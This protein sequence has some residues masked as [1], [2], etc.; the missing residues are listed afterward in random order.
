[1]AQRV[2]AVPRVALVFNNGSLAEI[3]GPD[4]VDNHAR[5]FVHGLRE[6]GYVDGRTIIIE[7]R[8][9]EGR[10]EGMPD[11]MQELVRLPVDVIVVMGR[12]ARDAQRATDTIPIVALVDDPEETGLV[13][14]LARPGR[15]ITGQ[16]GSA[17]PTIHGKRVQLLKEAFRGSRGSRCSTRST[18]TRR[19]RRV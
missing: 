12:G 7:R 17:G 18:L 19:R 11:L 8:S 4:P 5:E 16:A 10:Q 3:S 13:A 1:M 9:A 6:L 14:S 15:N 2:R